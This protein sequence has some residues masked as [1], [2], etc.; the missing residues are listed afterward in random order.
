M[1]NLFWL[2]F[3]TYLGQTHII[4]KESRLLF[5]SLWLWGARCYKYS[6]TAC[7]VSFQILSTWWRSCNGGSVDQSAVLVQVKPA[8]ICYTCN[9]NLPGNLAQCC[10]KLPFPEPRAKHWTHAGGI[11]VDCRIFGVQCCALVDA[12]S[13][14]TLVHDGL[15]PSMPRRKRRGWCAT[16]TMLASVTGAHIQMQGKR[17]FSWWRACGKGRL[18]CGHFTAVYFCRVCVRW[19]CSAAQ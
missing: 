18:V 14:I 4:L 16:T 19:S 10:L 11:Y 12:G 1:S 17:F 15:L 3:L 5:S 2:H 9:C 7:S 13:E 8:W 6:L